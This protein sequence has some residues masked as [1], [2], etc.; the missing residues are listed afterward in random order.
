MTT[1]CNMMTPLK[2]PN[3]PHTDAKD[4]EIN[5]MSEREF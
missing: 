4:I 2:V 3:S 1:Q 5:E